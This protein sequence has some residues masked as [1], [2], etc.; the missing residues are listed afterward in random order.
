MAAKQAR[1]FSGRAMNFTTE[2]IQVFKQIFQFIKKK[3]IKKTVLLCGPK[4]FSFH[5]RGHYHR[6]N[7]KID[8]DMR[9][10]KDYECKSPLQFGLNS[11]YMTKI[12]RSSSDKVMKWVIDNQLIVSMPNKISNDIHEINNELHIWPTPI[13]LPNECKIFEIGNDDHPIIFS[14]N[15]KYYRKK[16]NDVKRICTSIAVTQYTKYRSLELNYYKKSDKIISKTVFTDATKIQLHSKIKD[17]FEAEF[18]INDMEQLT[19]LFDDKKCITFHVSEKDNMIA[20]VNC[21]HFTFTGSVS[22]IQENI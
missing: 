22:P 5:F 9:I 18:D 12:M 15:N 16:I 14:L 2:N 20:I 21:K 6:V 8:V 19:N 4:Y 1:C 11:E 10:L 13:W 3:N 17:I 7:M